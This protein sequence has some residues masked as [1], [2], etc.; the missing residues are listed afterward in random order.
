LRGAAL[1]LLASIPGQ[2]ALA[3]DN[4]SLAWLMAE[5]G[6]PLVVQKVGE[7][8]VRGTEMIGV[9]S[10]TFSLSY[11]WPWFPVPEGPA[12]VI[13]LYDPLEV[14]YARA[15]IIFSDQTP[16]CGDEVGVMPV[17]TGTGAF[18]DRPTAKALDRAAAAMG[19]NC[20]LYDCLMAKQM[21]DSEFARMIALPDGST[22]PAFSTGYGD[23]AYPVY[24]L[25]DAQGAPTAAYVDFLG[26]PETYEWLA[27]PACPKLQS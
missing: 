27:P 14:A 12:R 9:D 24:L 1:V 16:I 20:N 13:A 17:D 19:P 3:E 8:S 4:P 22:Y 21:P 5:S 7:M 15:M 18:L 23:G 2:P 26:R 11:T 10:L 6:L 25:R